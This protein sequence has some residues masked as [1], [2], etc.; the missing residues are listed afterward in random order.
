MELESLS[1]FPFYRPKLFTTL[2]DYSL[3]QFSSDVTAGLVVGVVALPLCIALAIASGVSPVRGLTA[4]I[5][6][7][8]LVSA[9]GGSRVQIGGPAGAF[10]VIVFGILSDYGLDGL[11]MAT[12]MAGVILIVM[13]IAGFGVII[14]YIPHPVIVGFTSG[15]ALII[16]ISQ[17]SDFIGLNLSKPPSDLIERLS[18]YYNLLP[19]FNRSSLFLGLLAIAILILWPK[20]ITKRIPG[21]LIAIIVTTLLSWLFSLP[22]ETISS[23]FGD[24]P[25]IIP[26]PHLPEFSFERIRELISP[27]TTIAILAAIESLLSAVVSDGMI[28]GKHRSDT[29]LVGIGVANI[30]SAWFGGIPVTGAIARTATNVRNGGRTPVAGIVHALTLLAIMLLLAPF[31]GKIPLAVLAAV[32]IV[33][34][35]NMSEWR[36]VRAMMRSPKSDVAVLITTLS[37][38]VLMDL[39]VAIQVGMVLAAF[40]F[41]KRMSQ[42]T[43]IIPVRPERN[44]TL[45]EPLTSDLLPENRDIEIFEIDGPLF[46]GAAYKFKEAMEFVEKPPRV[47]ILRMKRLS[48]IDDT[49]IDALKEVAR[50]TKRKGTRLILCDVRAQPLDALTKSGVDEWL[51][52]E[53]ITLTLD[54][55]LIKAKER[56]V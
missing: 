20:F 38:T 55:A 42:A 18:A 29:E 54:G 44:G 15:I 43:Q 45:I 8:F 37:L 41:M 19:D 9:L 33:V 26:A 39:T 52:E 49:G 7:G 11:I 36:T 13:G 4:G 31:A 53:N 14:K 25:R 40:L 48:I 27:A 56:D 30:S 50:A 35:Y 6:G 47:R 17:I 3:R 34:A 46:F 23:R 5:I 2:R 24:I 21:S 28:G 22:V 1:F 16:F 12:I 10:V 51:G 32:L